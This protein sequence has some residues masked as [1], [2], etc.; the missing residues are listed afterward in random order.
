MDY[1]QLIRLWVTLEH[2]AANVRRLHDAAGTTLSV[3]SAGPQT[4]ALTWR[5]CDP[6]AVRVSVLAGLG[7]T[8]AVVS[9]DALRTALRSGFGRRCRL[10]M[11]G[12]V[13]NPSRRQVR[14]LLD[15][16]DAVVP[17][18]RE[19]AVVEAAADSFLQGVLGPVAPLS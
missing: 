18:V 11:A 16:T 10:A 13:I 8:T 6:L 9:R 7:C 14:R 17:P 4:L 15:A 2:R 12:L 5:S 19:P 3:S 1:L